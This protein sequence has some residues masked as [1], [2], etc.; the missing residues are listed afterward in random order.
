MS[1]HYHLLIKTTK[2]NLSR[3][4]HYINGS[5]TTYFNVKRRKTGHLFQGRYKSLVIDADSYFQELTRYIHLNPVRAKMVKNPEDYK[6]SS[7][8]AYV[9]RKRKDK[10]IGKEEIHKYLGMESKNY[11]FFVLN[12]MLTGEKEDDIFRDVYGGFLLGK[13][14]FIKEKLKELK[15]QVESDKISYSKELHLGIEPS[16]VIEEVARK[17][18]KNSEDLIDSKTRPAIVKQVAIYLIRHHTGLTNG[19]IGKIFKMK[20]QA[21]SKAGIKIERLMEENRKIRSQVNKLI[22]IFEG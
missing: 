3:I 13:T 17:F 12:G 16:L 15:T 19:E 14:Q 20:A 18:K 11:R 4:M 6:W 10:Y 22:S 8:N 2:A 5:Y 7:Y 1:N 9:S 21:V